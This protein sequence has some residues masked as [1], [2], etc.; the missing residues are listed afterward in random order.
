LTGWVED[1]QPGIDYGRSETGVDLPYARASVAGPGPYSSFN[2]P[3]GG[4]DADGNPSGPSLPC[5]RPPWARLV[6]VDAS[7]GEI[8]W[9][10]VLGL[11]ESLPDG[12]QLVGNSGSAGP[13]V[14][15]G[16]LVFIGA[17]N[18]AR[19]RAFDSATGEEL[20]VTALEGNANANPMSYADRNGQQRVAIN[21][22]GQLM[23]YGL[24]D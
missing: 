23:V 2:A 16:G 11:N 1:R 18:D 19:F 14:T 4:Y 12:R 5:Y 21:A 15:A 7:R 6:A 3:S 17:T 10:S 13:A 22:G 24:P 20:W 8:V 9:R